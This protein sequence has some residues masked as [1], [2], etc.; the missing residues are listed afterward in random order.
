MLSGPFFLVSFQRSSFGAIIRMPA[1]HRAGTTPNHLGA[2]FSL[3]IS[4]LPQFSTLQPAG[5][6]RPMEAGSCELVA[7][8]AREESQHRT[9]GGLRAQRHDLSR[10]DALAEHGELGVRRLYLGRLGPGAMS[11]RSARQ[12]QGNLIQAGPAQHGDENAPRMAVLDHAQAKL[13]PMVVTGRPAR[14][15]ITSSFSIPTRSAGL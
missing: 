6:T 4:A 12:G 1:G 10:P 7:Y 5:E 13:F 11:R 3:E 2:R 9:D 14:A 15:E 8:S